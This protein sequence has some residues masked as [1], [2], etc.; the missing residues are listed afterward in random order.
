MGASNPNLLINGDF[1]VWQRGTSFETGGNKY[2]LDRGHSVEC[3]VEQVANTS[4]AP[5]KYNA[6]LTLAEGTYNIFSQPL[7]DYAVFQGKTL[8][9][10]FWAKSADGITLDVSTYGNGQSFIHS[11]MD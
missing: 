2:T 7:E 5:C 11:Y 8:T 6:K 4:P 3:G 10:S 1:Q 9:A